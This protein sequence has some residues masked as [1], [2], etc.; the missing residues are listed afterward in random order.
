M[1]NELVMSHAQRFFLAWNGSI[2]G[3]GR[4]YSID[5]NRDFSEVKA[6]AILK[7]MMEAQSLLQSAFCLPENGCVVGD[8][9]WFAHQSLSVPFSVLSAHED[10][11]A[12]FDSLLNK[13]WDVSK[14]PL[15]EVVLY[16]VAPQHCRLYFAFEK[17]LCDRLS[18]LYFIDDFLRRYAG[19]PSQIPNFDREHYN[20]Q[21]KALDNFSAPYDNK[22]EL[23]KKLKRQGARTFNFN[24]DDRC[25][26]VTSP[27]YKTISLTLSKQQTHFLMAVAKLQNVSLY[28]VLTA[29]HAYSLLTVESD[30]VM[31]QLQTQ[32]RDYPDINIRKNLGCYTQSLLFNA[33]KKTS[34]FN[35]ANLTQDIHKQYQHESAHDFD[36]LQCHSLVEK[37]ISQIKVENGSLS[38]LQAVLV[39]STLKTNYSVAYLEQDPLQKCYNDLDIISYLEGSRNL[40]GC[41]EAVHK[42]HNEKLNMFFSYDQNYFSRETM[43]KMVESMTHL[44]QNYYEQF[45]DSASEFFAV[46]SVS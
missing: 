15:F 38:P 30:G 35:M 19:L 2:G 43:D 45:G 23:Q 44:I 3:A 16:K 20:Q 5:V 41:V 13:P 21:M 32:G 37:I 39:R 33:S 18:C 46:C 22:Y 6:E 7:D 4:C 40:A 10:P 34:F 26:T 12:I 11:D 14:P 25:F 9:Q 27:E 29:I 42:I 24:P 28:V 31:L 1:N 36:K 8:F 17:V